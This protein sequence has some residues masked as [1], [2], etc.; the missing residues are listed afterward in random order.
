MRNEG[1]H[2]V[3][4]R[5][6]LYTTRKRKANTIGHIMRWNCLLKHVNEGTIEGRMEVTGRRER[7]LK[8]L[9]DDLKENKIQE[10]KRSRRSH[11]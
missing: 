3:K 8:E 6:M 7:T 11:Y 4:N 2:R 9:L 10:T 5:N 1:L